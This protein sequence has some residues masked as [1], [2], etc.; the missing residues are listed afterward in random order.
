VLLPGTPLRSVIPTCLRAAF[1]SS[2]QNCCGAERYLV[3]AS[4]WDEFVEQAGAVARQMRQGP[5]LNGDGNTGVDMGA[6]VL[7]G[8]AR[9]IQG[10]ID[11]AVAAGA[12]LAAGGVLP[13]DHRDAVKGGVG[14]PQFYP[15]TVLLMPDALTNEAQRALPLLQDEVFGPVITAIRFETDDELLALANGCQF[16]LG[17][18]VFGSDAHVARVGQ[19]LEAGMLACNDYATCYM[20]QSLPFGGL[21]QSGFGKF[22]GVEGLRGC[23]VT[24]AS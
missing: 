11:G 15:P 19:R 24:K 9:R 5:P 16:A 18:N 10:L 13:S 1:Q 7:P 8:E 17:S 12:T 6:M 14:V 20:C 21:K 4:L 2:G 22:A 23:C 3:H